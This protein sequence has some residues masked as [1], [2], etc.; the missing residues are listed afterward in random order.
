MICCWI[1][2]E[3]TSLERKVR[4]DSRRPT[5]GNCTKA[6]RICQ[7]YGIQLSWPREGDEK[8]A[9]VLQYPHRTAHDLSLHSKMFLNTSSW[10]TSLSQEL[11]NG[12]N[13]GIKDLQLLSGLPLMVGTCSLS[14]SYY[15][16]P[17][18]DLFIAY[19]CKQRRVKFTRVL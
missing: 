11:A 17:S 2:N 14:S 4:C 16:S 18:P 3:L 9:I 1:F 13:T 7:G 19:S 12:M 5:C 10:D 8:R 6:R 15:A